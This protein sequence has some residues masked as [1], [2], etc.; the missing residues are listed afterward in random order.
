MID[1]SEYGNGWLY[2]KCSKIGPWHSVTCKNVSEFPP[3][4]KNC[5]CSLC[6]FI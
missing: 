4:S 6:S 3:Y 5:F 1:N 2:P